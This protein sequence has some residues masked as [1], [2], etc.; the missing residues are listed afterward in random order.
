MS[1]RPSLAAVA[2]AVALA[3]PAAPA[4]AQTP[5]TRQVE[6]TVGQ[7]ITIPAKGVAK[8]SEGASGVVDVRL[9]EDGSEFIVVG[10]AQGITT[11]LLIYEDGHRVQYTFTVKPLGSEVPDAENIRLDFYF[12]ELSDSD[13]YNVGVA[14]PSSIGAGGT[15]NASI[16]LTSG[17]F[18][19]ATA[20]IAGH[21]LPRLD[22]LQASGWAKVA[23]QASVI[24][25]NGKQ[26]EFNSGGEVNI[27]VQGSL[28]AEL[29]TIP[30]GTVVKVLPRYDE[31]TGRLELTIS[32]DFS[33]LSGTGSVPGRSVSKVTTVVNVEMNQ[34]V[35]LAGL[36]SQSEAATREGL[37]VLSQIPVIGALFGRHGKRTE[38]VQNVLFIV[39]SVVDV[40]KMDARRRIGEALATYRAF[41]GGAAAPELIDGQR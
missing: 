11:L 29:R 22:L 19:T 36:R 13:N 9:P 25:A 24:T 3:A 15:L 23:R 32:A 41:D 6:L 40:V 20:T 39:P 33:S 38:Q 26:A 30:F 21:P 34:A 16:D 4:A 37:P 2:T 7:Q 18:T 10:L 27:A 17:S 12:V 8:Y 1:I 14:W 31:K 5:E 35:V 28:A